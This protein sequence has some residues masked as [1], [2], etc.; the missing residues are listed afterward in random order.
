[1]SNAF[2]TK[3]KG[4]D[5]KNCLGTASVKIK[6]RG[7]I[8]GKLITAKQ[9]SRA[10]IARRTNLSAPTVSRI[11][12]ELLE[13]GIISEIGAVQTGDMGAPASMLSFNAKAGYVIGVNIGESVIQAAIADLSGEVI[14]SLEAPTKAKLGGDVTT[15]QVAKLCQQLLNV[16]GLHVEQL[17]HICVGIPGTVVVD[18]NDVLTVNAPDINGWHHYPLKDRLTEQ[19]GTS[20]VYIENAQNLAV[21]CEH[22]IGCATDC[23]DVV[24]VH[25]KAG[26]GAGLLVNG[27]LYRGSGGVAGEIGF[28]MPS[29]N[30]AP[31]ADSASAARHGCLEMAVGIGSIIDK[32]ELK[33]DPENIPDLEKLYILAADGDQAIYDV[34]RATW[35]YIGLTVVNICAILNPQMVVLGGDI[36]PLGQRV[37]EAVEHYVECFCLQPPEIRLSTKG[38]KTCLYGA[39]QMACSRVLH[40]LGIY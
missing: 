20:D 3:F 27:E 21:V 10:E 15:R 32:L 2:F 6:N 4:W 26:I 5:E 9:L 33:S 16:Q 34:L 1:M 11:I 17:F 25:V 24:F 14:S 35:E 37:K 23:T 28:I 18:E 19:L 13:T 22:T 39:V 40:K 29:L 7:I 38:N 36:L 8:L 12:T 31:I 30:Y